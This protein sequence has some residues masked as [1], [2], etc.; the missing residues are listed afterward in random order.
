MQLPAGGPACTDA[1]PPCLGT[2]RKGSGAERV[3]KSGIT[4]VLRKGGGRGGTL[5]ILGEDISCDPAELHSEMAGRPQER[6][7]PRPPVGRNHE[8][9]QPTDGSWRQQD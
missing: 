4:G 9:Q 2:R 6:P 8:L 3:D 7:C 1:L 5:R